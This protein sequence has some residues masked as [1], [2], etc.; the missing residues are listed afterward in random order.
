MTKV[1]AGET[2]IPAC[3]DWDGLDGLGNPIPDEQGFKIPVIISYEQGVYNF[4]IYD[5]ELMTDGFTIEAI[6]PPG[7]PRRN[8][9]ATCVPG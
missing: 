1:E 4:P 7:N 9:P 5:A 2:N 8:S 6:R 3:L